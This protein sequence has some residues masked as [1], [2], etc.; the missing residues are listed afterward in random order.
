M[1]LVLEGLLFYLIKYGI[2]TSSF[3]NTD[4]NTMWIFSCRHI[5]M[6]D[7]NLISDGMA[8]KFLKT[9]AINA[10]PN[11]AFTP[12][13][14]EALAKCKSVLDTVQGGSHHIA[15]D[16]FRTSS[17]GTCG[18]HVE[19]LSHGEDWLHITS[20]QTEK[21]TESQ[22]RMKV[23][24]EPC[25]GVV[26]VDRRTDGNPA[27]GSQLPLSSYLVEP[28]QPWLSSYQWDELTVAYVDTLHEDGVDIIM[29]RIDEPF[30]GYPEETESYYVDF[31]FDGSGSFLRVELTAIVFRNNE[32][33][34]TNET[35][36]IYSL[37]PERIS[38]QIQ[39]K[40]D[41]LSQ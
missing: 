23:G 40:Y 7:Q 41:N 13:E 22:Y 2:V 29:L 36:T 14:Q 24:G 33:W 39:F 4:F 28:E 16:K 31:I 8:E 6:D 3:L 21:G 37:D 17:A 34:T 11:P 5:S 27:E 15:W 10:E 1:Y 9:V 12:Q 20:L 25:F 26:G 38:R 19:Y 32:F 35:E 30:P 18:Y